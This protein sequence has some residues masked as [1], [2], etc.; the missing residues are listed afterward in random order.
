MDAPVGA[1]DVGLRR[2]GRH[3]RYP[4]RLAPRRGVRSAAAPQRQG[5]PRA[6]P[7][8]RRRWPTADPL[9][10]TSCGEGLDQARYR[11]Q[12]GPRRSARRRP[13]QAT[14]PDLRRRGA[15]H[16]GRHPRQCRAHERFRPGRRHSQRRRRLHPGG[17][18]GGDGCGA[19]GQGRAERRPAARRPGRRAIGPRHQRRGPAGASAS[20]DRRGFDRPLHRGPAGSRHGRRG[21]DRLRTVPAAVQVRACRAD[22]A[23]P[24]RVGTARGTAVDPRPGPARLHRSGAGRH[25]RRGVRR[26]VLPHQEAAGRLPRSRPQ[27]PP[28]PGAVPGRGGQDERVGHIDG[29]GSLA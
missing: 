23:R 27:A 26:R 25:P 17:L 11:H 1:T 21:L 8:R 5:R 20:R 18:R 13:A 28:A 12:L 9:H 29:T 10:A 24:R 22:H 16:L 3:G 14:P 4:R 15:G 2:A 19:C 7:R 6:D